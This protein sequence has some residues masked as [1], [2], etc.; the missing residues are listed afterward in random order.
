MAEPRTVADLRREI[1]AIDD[2]LVDL[3]AQRAAYAAAV[4]AA[5]GGDQ[6]EFL[7]RPAREAMMARRLAARAKADPELLERIWGE[8]TGANLAAQG[9]VGLEVYSPEDPGL[10]VSRARARFGGAA[11]L[12]WHPSAEAALAALDLPGGRIAVLPRPSETEDWWT[13]LETTSAGGRPI[14]VS[15]WLDHGAAFAMAR[16]PLEPSGQDR[17]WAVFADPSAALD[18]LTARGATAFRR[19]EV[20][21][22]GLIE[23]E[24]CDTP[25]IQDLGGAIVGLFAAP[26]LEAG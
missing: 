19:A 25:H 22:A 13:Q 7:W 6:A 23:A 1:D 16:A 14:R 17:L 20:P 12:T 3:I 8:L 15:A 5:K 21:G 4:R 10:A 11:P 9:P 24:G 26:P 2:A 18:A